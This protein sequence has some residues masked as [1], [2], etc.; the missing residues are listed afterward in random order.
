MTLASWITTVRLLLAPLVYWQLT[1]ATST[2]VYWGLGLLMLAGFTDILDGWV[3]RSRNEVSELGKA[4]DP[5][6]D[7]LII[8][9]A[10]IA[11]IG[12][13]LPLWLVGIYL[14][15]EIIQVLGGAWLIR[16]CRR[17]IP[18]NWW[19]KSGT[20]SFFAGFILFF[21]YK[22]LSIVV[23]SIAVLLSIGAFYTYA[24]EFLKMRKENR[25]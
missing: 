7:K 10:L 23:L 19:G 9:T 21:L 17:L 3:A 24:Q 16:S 2:G 6:A 1:S 18:A 11:L 20:V 13:G 12:R 25:L 14:V 4:L 22:P 15:K 5:V 8:L